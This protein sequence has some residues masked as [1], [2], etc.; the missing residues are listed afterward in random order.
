MSGDVATMTAD[1]LVVS[2]V[3]GPTIQGE[4]RHAGEVCSFVRL[5]RCNLTCVWCDT[6]YTWDWS[7]FDPSVELHR[8]QI[9]AVADD[10]ISRASGGFVVV[11]GG[12]PLLQTRALT[13]LVEII[14]RR[15]TAVHVETNGT[16]PP[17]PR[18]A[19]YS[20]SPKLL[21]SAQ[22]TWDRAYCPGALRL[23]AREEGAIKL[24]VDMDTDTIG[25]LRKAVGVLAECGWRDRIDLMPEGADPITLARNAPTVEVLAADL[26]LGYSPRLHV[27]ELGGGRGV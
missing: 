27:S 25:A 17:V 26:G 11:S 12:E 20:V 23:L 21:P 3:F 7:R 9:E 19:W 4:G 8:E 5:G 14:T 13:L 15:G 6:P 16:R 10:A 18:V 22:I 1:T 2:E 24:V